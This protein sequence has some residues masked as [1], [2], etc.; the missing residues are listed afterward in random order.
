MHDD[1]FVNYGPPLMA[2]RSMHH[3]VLPGKLLLSVALELQLDVAD[4]EQEAVALP[5]AANKLV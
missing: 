1:D 4:K 3:V 5:L 2:V